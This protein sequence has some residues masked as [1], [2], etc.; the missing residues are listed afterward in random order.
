ML[1][2]FML[3][4]PFA[5]KTN[6]AENLQQLI[7]EAPINSVL[8]LKAKTYAGPVLINK[9]LT[10]IGVEGTVIESKTTGISI[11]KTADVKLENITFKTVQ[12]PIFANEVIGLT[13]SK[14]TFSLQDEGVEL[15]KMNQLVIEHNYM[16]GLKEAHFSKKPNGYEIYESKGIQIDNVKVQN[17]QDGLYF[18]RIE[19]IKVTNTI[20]ESG[21]Y[22]L[23]FMYGSEVT[24]QYN[25]VSNNVTGLM[26]MIINQL[27]V[28][29]NTV[30]RQLALN[31]NGLYLY[32]VQQ[33]TI[34]Q[35]DFFENT[36]ATVWNRVSDTTFEHNLFQSNGTVF[37]AE[38]S[39]AV[40]V[41]NN[42]FNGN[43]LVARS[44]KAGFILENNMYDDYD[45][46]D[47]DGNGIGDT[48]HQTYTSFG[49]WMV[50]KP[51]YQYF[52]ESPSVVLLNK[53]DHETETTDTALLVD[54]L[55]KIATL[56]TN[57]QRE[58]VWWQLILGFSSIV[59]ISFGW[60]KLQ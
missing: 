37:E 46:Y 49:Q 44:D 22:G 15:R 30:L 32:D 2:V 25:T 13:L 51:V 56:N 33:A 7:D 60:R 19:N 8:T 42:I 6:A 41:R 47:F 52:I 18:E 12:Q 50:R 16:T 17:V 43:I 58:I 48:P 55:P 54:P 23:H 29:Y 57:L 4:L 35:N 36:V 40:E 27:D 34:Q 10:I 14:L 38:K 5:N 45:G 59:L 39:P 20:S 11:E 1:F 53:M 21:R 31:S 24:L 26:L 3:V 9:P 28:S